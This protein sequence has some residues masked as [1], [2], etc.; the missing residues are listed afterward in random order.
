MLF[1]LTLLVTITRCTSLT[2]LT[3]A[4]FKGELRVSTVGR[5]KAVHLCRENG[6]DYE[7]PNAFIDDLEALEL[8]SGST[9]IQIHGV[10]ANKQSH[11]LEIL[12]DKPYV[13]VIHQQ[14]RRLS[15]PRTTGQRT[16]MVVRVISD[17][18]V[19]RL[20]PSLSKNHLKK[21]IFGDPTFPNRANFKKQ[22]SLCSG[23]KLVF[24]PATHN[25]DSSGVV[26]LVM[27][28]TLKNLD[29][30][31]NL[32]NEVNKAFE[33]EYGSASRYDHVMFCLPRGM[34]GEFLAYALVNDN[35][36]Y[37]SDPWCGSLSATMHEIAHN[38]GMC[39]SL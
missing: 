36:S 35:H 22:Y 14:D 21:N 8:E 24:N 19:E 13:E 3:C 15:V 25:R 1:L 4:Y 26:N 5:G 27:K 30:T 29:F 34:N 18:G 2:E 12:S 31:I 20:E 9:M 37:F 23:K 10:Q 33:A 38:L 11:S 6:V 39:K 17:T 7:I 28:R 32:E 16:L